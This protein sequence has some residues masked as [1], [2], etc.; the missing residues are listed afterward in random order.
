MR[1]LSAYAICGN[2]RADAGV[3]RK[4]GRDQLRTVYDP[5]IPVNV[6][7]LGLIYACQIAPLD[8]GNRIDLKM[9]MTAPGC[10]MA[11]CSRQTSSASSQIAQREGN[12]R[13]SGI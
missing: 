12:Q 3:Q 10:G 11:T 2:V 1:T 7:D 5:E 4:A 6:V 8:E 9:T 13:G